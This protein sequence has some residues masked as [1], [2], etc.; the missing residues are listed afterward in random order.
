[1]KEIAYV[2][3]PWHCW[4]LHLS[5][6]SSCGHGSPP[7][8]GCFNTCLVV[9]FVP[10]PHVTLQSLQGSQE[11]TLQ[12]T[13]KEKL[14][15]EIT[16]HFSLL[17]CIER[18]QVGTTFS[19]QKRNITFALFS[20]A[21]LFF[22]QSWTGISSFFRLLNNSPSSRLGSTSAGCATVRPRGPIFNFAVNW[23]NKK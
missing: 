2:Y 9:V 23:T 1:M 10:L 16:Q 4:V 21:R 22:L 7:C 19:Y 13:S 17:Q 14:K 5:V 11:S 20:V 12:S 6:T 18:P 8:C 15:G 3:I